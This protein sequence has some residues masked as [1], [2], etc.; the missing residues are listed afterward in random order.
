MR[1]NGASV[2]VLGSSMKK[3]NFNEL[4]KEIAEKEIDKILARCLSKI[5]VE[6]KENNINFRE[7]VYSR[8]ESER[9]KFRKLTGIKIDDILDRHKVAALFYVAFVDSTGGHSFNVF[10]SGNKRLSNAEAII[11]HETALNIACGILE[12]FIY[13]DRGLDEGYKKYVGDNGVIEPELICFGKK[14]ETRYKIE[15]LKQLI[16]AQK[17]CKLSV[18]QLALTFF[19]LENNTKMSYKLSKAAT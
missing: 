18:S 1:L 5:R 12:N 14:S 2:K 3:D 10:G 19:S 8:Y 16:C 9:E 15:A 7:T 17:E 4:W 11:T 6:T 13:V